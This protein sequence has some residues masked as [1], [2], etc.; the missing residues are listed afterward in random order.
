MADR[1]TIVSADCHGGAQLYE[2]R[3]YLTADLHDEF[4]A[5]AR[6]YAIPW[7]DLRGEDAWRNWDSMRAGCARSQMSLER[8]NLLVAGAHRLGLFVVLD[9]FP[10]P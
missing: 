3:D 1:Y 9:G 5:W 8:Y 4:D 6:D 7:E 10:V 2:Y